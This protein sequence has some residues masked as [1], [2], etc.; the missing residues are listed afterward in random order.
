LLESVGIFGM[1]F[2]KSVMDS[3]FCILS[4]GFLIVCDN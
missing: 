3:K 1:N 4:C 2:F